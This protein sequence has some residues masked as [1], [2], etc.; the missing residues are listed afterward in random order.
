VRHAR[1]AEELTDQGR[2]ELGVLV[3]EQVRLPRSR[4]V[5]QVGGHRGCQC[6]TEHPRED[7]RR[8]LGSLEGLR[9][10]EHGGPQS[11]FL[12]TARTGGNGLDA[13]A[14]HQ[15]SRLHGGRPQDEEKRTRKALRPCDR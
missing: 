3:D 9:D 5:D 6:G 8:A 10:V 7:V 12:G 11:P 14:V 4:D 2:G 1:Q 15:D 13:L